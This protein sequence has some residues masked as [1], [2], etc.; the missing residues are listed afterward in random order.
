MGISSVGVGSSI[1]TQDVLDQLRS[2]DEAGQIKPIELDLALENDKK[3]ALN[4]IM[5]KMDALASSSLDLKDH[6]LYDA[7]TAS[8]VGSSVE[9]SAAIKTD[10]QDFTLNVTKLATKQVEQSGAFASKDEVVDALAGSFD[11]QVGSDAPITINYEAG[12]SL[13]DIKN[14][15][16]KEAGSLVD[17]TVVQISSGE[18]RLFLSSDQTG[19][20]REI[21]ISNGAGL[22]SRLTTDTS[23][24]PAHS[25][26][27]VTNPT[28][29]Y[30]AIQKGIDSEFTFN[31]QAI[32]RS[33]NTIDDLITGLDITLKE[34]GTSTVKITQDREEIL[35][36]FDA[37]VEKYNEN[38]T[39][40]SKM[41]KQSANS[42]ERGIFAAESTIK[43]IK[44][45]LQEMMG[46]VGGGV[47]NLTQ[48]G[49]EIDKDGKLSL[50]KTVLEDKLEEDPDNVEIFFSGGD[51]DNG[52]G[53]TTPVDGAFVELTTFIE[54]YT[55]YD[56]LLD[57]F[58]DSIKSSISSLEDRKES[59]TKRLDA[60]YEIMKKQ[61]IAYDLMIN[62]INSASSM[63]VQMANAQTAAQNS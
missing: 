7:R 60:K 57:Q 22:D 40:L 5:T 11:L 29:A 24:N 20:D 26:D 44:T 15:I 51:F 12:A 10:I 6:S 28:P 63:F 54:G 52:D 18:F 38:I 8:V 43:N 59:A 17:A 47:G 48:Y 30:A 58:E 56:K 50:D 41:V 13:E 9:V 49:F 32:T 61:F 25:Y 19:A 31:G 62:K 14:L 42:E 36:K 4:T 39:E 3:K 45:L 27:P 46:T 37:F 35:K 34:V 16:N 53:T 55:K 23:L 1:L 21:S 2:A 33:S